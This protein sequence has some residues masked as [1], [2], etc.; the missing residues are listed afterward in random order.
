MAG[1]S[2]L[3][4]PVQLE[5]L[6]SWVQSKQSS[7]FVIIHHNKIILEK[8]YGRRRRESKSDVFSVSKSVVS[9]LIGIAVGQGV[10]KLDDSVLKYTKPGFTDSKTEHAITIRHVLQMTSGLD[11]E[12]KYRTDPGLSWHYN[13]GTAWHM[14]KCVLEGAYGQSLQAISN[15]HLFDKIGI[16]AQWVGRPRASRLFDALGYVVSVYGSDIFFS[17]GLSPL[18]LMASALCGFRARSLGAFA[19]AWASMYI[20]CLLQRAYADWQKM[21]APRKYFGDSATT[22]LHASALDCAKLGLLFL[23]DGKWGHDTVVPPSYIDACCRPSQSINP[24]YSLMWWLNGQTSH[25]DPVAIFSDTE[26]PSIKGA[27][28]PAAPADTVAAMGFGVQRIYVVPS[29]EL[30]VVRLGDHSGGGAFAATAPFDQQLWE[31][32]KAMFPL[33]FSSKEMAKERERVVPSASL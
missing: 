30:V 12:M 15:E 9:L 28:I 26:P 25:M 13:L 32:L 6:S 17:R 5:A 1:S 16:R 27:L 8:Y 24:A 33:V 20:A 10:L 22:S 11:D 31:K 14:L 23:S 2:T 3:W 29:K 7:A 18:A 4:D 19:G 21:M